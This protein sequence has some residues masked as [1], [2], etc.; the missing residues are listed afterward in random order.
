MAFCLQCGKQLPDDAKFCSECGTPVG[1]TKSG[2]ESNRQHA[3]AGKVIK[4]P[5]CGTEIP[6][7]TAICPGC[8]HE[9]NSDRVSASLKAFIAEINECDEAIAKKPPIKKNWWEFGKGAL[10]VEERKKVSVIE[11]FPFPNE[12]ES[13]LEALLL[14]RSKV[15]FLAS[16]PGNGKTSYW[17]RLWSTKAEQL[18]VKAE[19]MLNGDAAAKTAYNDIVAFRKRIKK[20][21]RNRFMLAVV[22]ML[23]IVCAMVYG[24]SK[25]N[26]A[27]IVPK[28]LMDGINSVSTSGWPTEG[29]ATLLPATESKERLF[30]RNSD[31]VLEVEVDDTYYS[32]TK[33]Y[34]RQCKEYGFTL[35]MKEEFYSTYP[36]TEEI[37]FAAYNSEGYYLVLANPGSVDL[38]IWLFAPDAEQ[39]IVWEHAILSQNIPEMSSAVGSIKTN[40]KEKLMI[41]VLNVTPAQF[42]GYCSL[43]ADAGYAIDTDETETTFCGYNNEGYYLELEYLTDLS[44]MIISVKAPAEMSQ[45]SWPNSAI[46]KLV[47]KPESLRGRITYDRSD[48]FAVYIADTTK[49]EYQAYVEECIDEGFSVDYEKYDTAFYGDNKKGYSLTVK[50][51]GGHVMFISIDEPYDP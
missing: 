8:G 31:T 15:S 6:S 48:Y 29:L 25:I 12:R 19:I 36:T 47:P 13:I 35:N 42:T 39:E 5:S 11:N 27:D 28:P 26:F 21:R 3:Y 44:Y 34:I 46:A 32:D 7:F 14:I 30:I 37:E 17:A 50:Y 1:S 41:R 38:K 23:I 33:E 16:E 18:Y 9:I 51:T 10:T 40:T 49:E 24:I 45:I 22:G 43:C 2:Y 20:K 4:C